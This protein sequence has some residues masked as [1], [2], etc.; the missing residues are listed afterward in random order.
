M[1]GP[2]IIMQRIS[3]E[4]LDTRVGP[5][6]TWLVSTLLLQCFVFACSGDNAAGPSSEAG[7]AHSTD[8]TRTTPVV[9]AT[10]R[11]EEFVDR[12]EALG[13]AH[14]NESVI[15][16]AQVTEMVTDVGFEDGQVVEAGHVLVELTSQEE[17]AKLAA[18]RANYDESLRQYRRISDLVKQGSDSRSNLDQRVAARDSAAALLAELQAKLADRLIVA[19]FAGVLGLRSVSTGTV[20]K[21]GDEIT[22]HDDIELITLDFS[23]PDSFLAALQPGLEIRASSV[24]Y[25]DTPFFGRVSAVDTRVDQRTRAVRVRALSQMRVG[26]IEVSLA[27]DLR[28]AENF[29]VVLAPNLLRHQRELVA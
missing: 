10:P 3:P 13:T 24:A 7:E 18:A 19:P 4:T 2:G 28:D 16:T 26:T 27:A 14:A 1:I 21:P 25:P 5:L 8:T 23:V 29:V 22:T 12:I 20:V 6:L 9:V 11:R 15:I 17:S